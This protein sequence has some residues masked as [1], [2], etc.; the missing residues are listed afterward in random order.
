MSFTN[1]LSRPRNLNCYSAIVQYRESCQKFGE[2]DVRIWWSILLY[3][4]V[5]VVKPQIFWPLTSILLI[6][7]VGN[8]VKLIWYPKLRPLC[9]E[10]K[11]QT[12]PMQFSSVL[13]HISR[14][15]MFLLRV[16]VMNHSEGISCNFLGNPDKSKAPIWPLSQDEVMI[17]KFSQSEIYTAYIFCREN[18]S[19][20]SRIRIDL[21]E[22]H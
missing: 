16:S 9:V 11:V 22:N 1:N 20:Q 4:P 7:G 10:V 15:V 18:L 8:D 5:L 17:F 14:L 21:I 2:L 12:F 19:N 13:D 3:S 6:W